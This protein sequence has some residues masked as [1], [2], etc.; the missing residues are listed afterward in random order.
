MELDTGKAETG[1]FVSKTREDINRQPTALVIYN[2]KTVRQ[3]LTGGQEV[4]TIP[5]DSAER[6]KEKSLVI[7]AGI[8]YPEEGILRTRPRSLTVNGTV[9][10]LDL[11]TNIGRATI[12]THGE[13]DIS[14]HFPAV[15][16]LAIDSFKEVQAVS[17]LIDSALMAANE[18][19][20]NDRVFTF[21]KAVTAAEKKS[22]V[23][24]LPK[25]RAMAVLVPADVPSFYCMLISP[26]DFETVSKTLKL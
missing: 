23:A 9:V 11:Q 12:G 4:N 6:E 7:A 10:P 21:T 19:V 20:T 14:R 25:L 18:R 24:K 17:L 15:K 1:L 26:D 3:T 5:V 16:P 13:L 22:L 8:I 2:Q